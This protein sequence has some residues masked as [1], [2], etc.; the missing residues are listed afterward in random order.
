MNDIRYQ[1]C[2]LILDLLRRSSLSRADL[3]RETGLSRSTVS[4]I[5]AELAGLGL[6]EETG[7]LNHR[8]GRPGMLL[9]LAGDAFAV[10]GVEL[11]RSRTH[12]VALNLDGHELAEYEI[13]GIDPKA[14]SETIEPCVTA[15]HHDTLRTRQLLGVGIGVRA[16]SIRTGRATAES[17]LPAWRDVDLVNA[18][19][20]RPTCR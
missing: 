13:P 18:V 5:V 8:G 3:S 9:Q 7:D 14:P 17:I 1:N 15:R 2:R 19:R 12:I 11:G 4:A 16:P 10:I 20:T 6:V